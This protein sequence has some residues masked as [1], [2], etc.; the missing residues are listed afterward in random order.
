MERDVIEF[1][2]NAI[3]FEATRLREETL[4]PE[5]LLAE[6]LEQREIDSLDLTETLFAVAETFGVEIP[7]GDIQ[8]VFAVIPTI[9]A[10]YD[11]VDKAVNPNS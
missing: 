6:R 9:K 10:L 7:D 8:S 1:R 3:I 5:R 2:I 11:Y 4:F